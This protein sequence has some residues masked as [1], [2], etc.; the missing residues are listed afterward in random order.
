ML[1]GFVGCGDATEVSNPSQSQT[2]SSSP[3][4]PN[5][6]TLSSA[7]AGAVIPSIESIEAGKYVPLSRP[8]YM[9]V[10]KSSLKRPEVAAFMKYVLEEGQDLVSVVQYIRLDKASLE[11]SRKQLSEAV[12]DVKIDGEVKGKIKIDGSSTV[13]PIAQAAAETFIGNHPDVEPQVGK[14]GTGGGFKKFVIGETDISN[15]S[16]PISST[17]REMCEKNKVEYLEL[18][19]AIDGM[20]VVVNPE[21]TFCECLTV[22]QLKKL[23]EPDSKVGK[24]NELNPD[25]PAEDIKLYGPDTDSGTFDY[26]TE[27]ICGKA[28]AGRSDYISSTEDNVLVKGVEGDKFSLGYFGYAYYAENSKNL[29]IVAIHPPA[30]KDSAEATPPVKA[31]EPEKK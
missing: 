25:W 7:C 2:S 27:V 28:K 10:N 6:P 11:D 15:A 23:W 8:L 20:V 3:S 21:N 24:W 16:R 14:S 31:A 30:R 18:K 13:F 5:V 12:A 19:V 17:E 29:K 22:D 1:I 4:V 26:F 9:Y